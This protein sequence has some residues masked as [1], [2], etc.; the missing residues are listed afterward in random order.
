MVYAA[1]SLALVTC[2]KDQDDAPC[3][4]DDLA[5]EIAWLKEQTEVYAEDEYSYY[6][7]ATL[8]ARTVFYYGNCNPAINYASYL[9]TCQ[10]DTLGFTTEFDDLLGNRQ[11]VWKPE[12]AVCT[13]EDL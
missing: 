7:M 1:A 3:G 10:G 4:V 2:A 13:F 9:Q 6:M 12:N 11:V 5:G 8:Q